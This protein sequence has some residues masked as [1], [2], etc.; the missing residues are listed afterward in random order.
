[1]QTLQSARLTT[2]PMPQCQPSTSAAHDPPVRPIHRPP[3]ILRHRVVAPP[4]EVVVEDEADPKT[5]Q[6]LARFMACQGVPVEFATDPAFRDLVN[7]INPTAIIP[8]TDTLQ[9]YI[10]KQGSSR[11]PLIN[12][13]KTVGPLSVTMDL[14]G[15]DDKFLV[16]SIHYFEDSRL[17]KYVTCLRKLLVSEYDADSILNS[18]RRAIHATNYSNVRFTNLVVPNVDCY[19]LL[20]RSEVVKRY[21]ICFYYFMTQFVTDLFDINEFSLGLMQ[22]REFIRLMKR[23]SDCYGKFRKMQMTKNASPNLP[24]IDD[25]EWSNTLTFLTKCLV[26]HDT[27]TEFC[28]KNAVSDYITNET[29]SYLI[30]LQRLLQQCVKHCRDLSTHH[31][32]ISQVIPAIKG[33]ENFLTSYA[34]G[35]RFQKDI[36]YLLRNTFSHFLSS[37]PV[38]DRYNMATFLD[39]RYVHRDSI[40]SAKKWEELENRL[41]DEFINMDENTAKQ[42]PQEITTMFTDDRQDLI[43]AELAN[44]R[45]FS[46]INRPDEAENSF[47]WWLRVQ[48]KLPN[49]SIMAREYLACPAVTVDASYY[50][51][52]GGTMEN[53]CEVYPDEKVETMLAFSG[54]L[55]RFRGRGS[56]PNQITP[57]MVDA[58]KITAGRVQKTAHYTHDLDTTPEQRNQII[59]AHYPPPPTIANRPHHEEKPQIAKQPRVFKYG[60]Y[61]PIAPRPVPVQYL[62][63]GRPV[64]LTSSGQEIRT[65]AVPIRQVPLR[66]K[67]LPVPGQRPIVKVIIAPPKAI[68]KPVAPTAYQPPEEESKPTDLFQKEVKQEVIEPDLEKVKEEPLDEM[69]AEAPKEAKPDLKEPKTEPVV[70]TI[71]NPAAPPPKKIIY[72]QRT[73]T[74]TALIKGRPG[75]TAKLV[76]VPGKAPMPQNITP[77]NFVQKF[78]GKQNFIAKFPVNKSAP[79]NLPP[80]I[81]IRAPI[82]TA[83]QNLPKLEERKPKYILMKDTTMTLLRGVKKQEEVKPE[84]FDDFGHDVDHFMDVPGAVYSQVLNE[85]SAAQAMERH[86]TTIDFHKRKA[87]NRRCAVCGHMETHEKLK[88]VTIDNEKLLIMLGCIYRRELTLAQAQ[89]FLARET[90]TY[91]CRIHF[92]ETLDEIYSMLKM[93]P[94]SEFFSPTVTEIHNVLI[95]ASILRQH[96]S[97]VQLRKIL[98]DFVDRYR[99]LRLPKENPTSLFDDLAEP[100]TTSNATNDY[101]EEEITPKVYRQPRK[102]VLEE[103][104]HDGTVKV[105]EQ[106]DFKLPAA[107]PV[108]EGDPDAPARCCFCSMRGERNGMLRVPK[109]EDRLARWIEKLGPEFEARLRTDEENLICR[110]HFPEEAFSSRGRLLKGMIPHT[111][112]EKVEVTYKIQGNDFLRLKTRKS[113][114]AKSATINLAGNQLYDSDEE[115]EDSDPGPPPRAPPQPPKPK[116]PVGRPRKSAKAPVYSDSEEEEEFDEEEDEWD[117]YRP[118]GDA[119]I[120]ADNSA[121]L[122]AIDE[123]YHPRRQSNGVLPARKRGRPKKFDEYCGDMG[124]PN[125]APRTVKRETSSVESDKSYGEARKP[126]ARP[127]PGRHNVRVGGRF[128]KAVKEETSQP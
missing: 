48:R 127:G 28:E 36:V 90:K 40:Y 65:Q 56:T 46:F 54:Q 124:I 111:A 10:D 42:Y 22:L 91:I 102:Q 19:N 82:P 81:S 109:G 66:G 32:S 121:V 119:E 103:D 27:F 74:A 45:Q 6:L 116:R 71:L 118:G 60:S 100:P 50:F 79:I 25:G 114:T 12:F 126:Q 7:Y 86:I 106:E 35:Y 87:C 105:I 101:Y 55:Q 77:H 97:P 80:P 110:T 62:K 30:Y 31:S 75:A 78:A 112:P 99:Y 53:I 70:K 49:L 125:K 69:P 4:P 98:K 93:N 33:L 84:P 68:A 23:H 37:G 18:I 59:A 20:G 108:E 57:S 104:Q 47:I 14:A 1:M 43:R 3:G 13:Q 38:N 85:T 76:R 34:M 9:K 52:H 11:K 39:P 17:R 5:V 117:H 63:N 115:E 95:T 29:C 83:I 44:Y 16:F 26:L 128:V 113:H 120:F 122:D 88:N 24:L 51:L 96:I 2:K 94:R 58:L 73:P 8:Q 61:V 21:H 72:I 15:L 41:V 107:K 89:E 123:E 67:P 92:G 64:Y